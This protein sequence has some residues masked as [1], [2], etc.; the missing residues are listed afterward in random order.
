MENNASY[1][2]VFIAILS[3]CHFWHPAIS[4]KSTQMDHSE[5]S[6]YLCSKTV[7]TTAHIVGAWRL[8]LSREDSLTAIIQFCSL[9]WQP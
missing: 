6:S 2:Q 8:P 3:R 4:L 1:A 9:F 5:W 7:C